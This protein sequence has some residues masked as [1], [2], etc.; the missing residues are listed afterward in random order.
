[1]IFLSHTHADKPLIAPI[2]DTLAKK[3]G[4]DN[5]FYDSWSVQPGDGIID[6]MSKGLEDCRYFFYFMSNKSISSKMVDL[7]WQ[8]ALFKSTKGEVKIIPVKLDDCIVPAILLQTLYIDICSSG[9]EMATRQMIDVIDGNNTYQEI[10]N[11]FVNEY[12]NVELNTDRSELR[13]DFCVKAYTEPS[14]RYSIV[15]YNDENDISITNIDLGVHMSGFHEGFVSFE[16]KEFNGFSVIPI[17]PIK[18]NLPARFLVNATQGKI[19]KL[20]A[21]LRAID[22]ETSE[23]LPIHFN[24]ETINVMPLEYWTN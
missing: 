3:Y 13:I 24:G 22:L 8:N 18:P 20:L 4:K 17:Q 10:S 2:A 21:I 16:G 14:P 11:N 6:R 15:L 5:V 7:E 1:M 9:I 19:I 23:N 12:A